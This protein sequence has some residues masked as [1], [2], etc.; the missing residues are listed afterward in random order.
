MELVQ[1]KDYDDTS[2]SLIVVIYALVCYLSYYAIKY[3]FLEKKV[4]EVNEQMAGLRTELDSMK[5]FSRQQSETIKMFK[6]MR[7]ELDSMK[8]TFHSTCKKMTSCIDELEGRLFDVYNDHKEI[9][10]RT[11]K[12]E[13]K[14]SDHKEMSCRIDKL[15]TVSRQLYNTFKKY[16]YE[17]MIV[18]YNDF[19]HKETNE[20]KKVIDLEDKRDLYDMFIR[21][22]M[23]KDNTGNQLDWYCINM[24]GRRQFDHM[25]WKSDL[26]K[27][28]IRVGKIISFNLGLDE[29]IHVEYG[30]NK[31]SYNQQTGLMNNQVSLGEVSTICIT[32][33]TFKCW[34]SEDEV[35]ST[36]NVS[37]E[38]ELEMFSHL[39]KKYKAYIYNCVSVTYSSQLGS[40]DKSVSDFFETRDTPMYNG[41]IKTS[42]SVQK[43][44]ASGLIKAFDL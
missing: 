18:V 28:L 9:S 20:I 26:D 25:T 10:S 5:E 30:I 6:E 27:Q 44:V 8:I 41:S 13:D 43:I 1:Y 12:L 34:S 33:G 31:L 19:I 16:V 38:R 23:N 24:R 11:Y 7:G 22:L 21:R 15:E 36:N 4:S 17:L 37:I 14:L 2:V 40:Q 32:I 42:M 29:D 39:C 35:H 3:S